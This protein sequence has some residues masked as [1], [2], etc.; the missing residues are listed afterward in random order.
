MRLSDLQKRVIAQKVPL[1]L[2][3]FPNAAA[4]YS[5][6]KLRT[7]YTGNCIEVRRSSD[8][9][10]QN[11]GFVNNRLDT[12]SLLSF[13]GAGN[14]FVRT[15]YDQSGLNVNPIATDNNR[16]PQIVGSGSV[17]TFNG[18][19][20][21]LFNG[22]SNGLLRSS[23]FNSVGHGNIFAI[24][25]Q[26][27]QVTIEKAIIQDTVEGNGFTRAGIFYRNVAA[28]NQGLGIG[29]RR[30]TT[31]S[32]QAIGTQAWSGNELLSTSLFQWQNALLESY[33]NGLSNG[34]RGFQAAGITSI[35]TFDCAIGSNRDYTAFFFNGTIKELV[36]F[37]TDQSANR[38]AIESN[39]NSY[40]NIY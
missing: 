4:A 13:V 16:Q 15:W 40:Y 14:G 1:L 5:L 39:I 24:H 35:S 7:A 21:I 28:G 3:L 18:K 8:N 37:T 11:I 2:D 19:P 25:K 20:N 38:T 26:T 29:G 22:T 31:D 30:I 9:A 32:F 23:L 10:L 27:S 34:S 33:I 6:R 36:I 12:A 17:L